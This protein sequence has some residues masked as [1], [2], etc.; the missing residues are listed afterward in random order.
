MI[1]CPPTDEDP[2]RSQFNEI[3]A[4]RRPLKADGPMMNNRTARPTE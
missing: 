1:F 3:K 4:Q 2:Q